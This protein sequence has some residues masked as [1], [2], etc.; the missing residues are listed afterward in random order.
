MTQHQ[1]EE[2]V[3][4]LEKELASLKATL[5]NGSRPKDW[6]RTVGMFAGDEVMKQICAEALRLREEDRRRARRRFAKRQ[7]AGK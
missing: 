4:A 1:L 6:R 5:V 7:K 3:C 2:R